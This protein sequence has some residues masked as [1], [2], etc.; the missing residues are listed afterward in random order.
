[1]E[2]EKFEVDLDDDTDDDAVTV[3]ELADLSEDFWL[4]SLARSVTVQ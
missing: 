1:M 2:D 4:V 3:D